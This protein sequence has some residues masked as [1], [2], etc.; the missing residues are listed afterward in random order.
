MGDKK[1]RVSN[2]QVLKAL[3]NGFDRLITAITGA[4]IAA[5]T[6]ATPDTTE[7]GEIKVDEKYLAHMQG[8]AQD[9]ATAKGENVVL[10][11]R[12]NKA[13][14][15]KLAYA[16]RPRFDDVVAKQ[17]SCLGAVKEFKA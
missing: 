16:L 13:G 4:A 8:K 12:R 10:Y 2:E 11:A 1:T 9:H 15:Q 3:D 14:Q 17:P 7:G 6:A 5:P